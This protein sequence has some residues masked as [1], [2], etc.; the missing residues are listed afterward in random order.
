VKGGQLQG[1]VRVATGR[2]VV[3]VCGLL[4]EG[5]QP[6]LAFGLTYTHMFIR[7]VQHAKNP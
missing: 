5:G 2:R 1:C 4:G 3:G 6:L 7:F